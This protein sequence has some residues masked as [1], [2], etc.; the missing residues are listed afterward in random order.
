MAKLRHLSLKGNLIRANFKELFHYAHDLFE[1][2]FSHNDFV[3]VPVLPLPNLIKLNV[4]YNSIES[5]FL[6]ST[7]NLIRLK[8]LF[9]NNNRLRTVPSHIW[10]S[11]PKLK[12][13]DLSGNFF[14]VSKLQSKCNL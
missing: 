6:N 1:L 2:N 9:L 14:K 11:L 4:A 10:Q 12:F 3:T 5:V 8:Y 13:L 7:D